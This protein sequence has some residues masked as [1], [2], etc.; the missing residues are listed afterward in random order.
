MSMDALWRGMVR[1]N[2]ICSGFGSNSGR[3]RRSVRLTVDAMESRV[4]PANLQT[5]AA[6]TPPP[7][8]QSGVI[9][10]SAGNLFGTT[11]QGGAYGVGSVYEIVAGTNTI[12]PNKCGTMNIWTACTRA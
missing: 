8:T 6:F 5:L 1:L 10:D 2:R 3:Q 11:S 9:A 4:V 7:R 12:S